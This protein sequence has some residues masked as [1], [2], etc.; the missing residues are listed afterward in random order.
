MIVV[1][2]VTITLIQWLFA[3]GGLRRKEHKLVLDVASPA[4]PAPVYADGITRAHDDARQ[5]GMADAIHD[6]FEDGAFVKFNVD[7]QRIVQLASHLFNIEVSKFN[8]GYGHGHHERFEE[9]SVDLEETYLSAYNMK[10]YLFDRI[11]HYSHYGIFTFI[12][13]YHAN[14]IN[15]KGGRDGATVQQAMLD[16]LFPMTSHEEIWEEYQTFKWEKLPEE[17]WQFC[18]ERYRWAKDQWPNLSD[19]ITTVWTLQDFG[20]IPEEVDVEMVIS[21]SSDNKLR[22][23]GIHTHA[24][25]TE[26]D[27]EELENKYQVIDDEDIE[28]SRDDEDDQN[29]EDE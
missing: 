14:W 20:L 27:P 6:M 19:R 5:R 26:I 15:P 29:N 23:I 21:V 3:N 22:R 28:S 4:P 18:R 8:L 1:S 7:S 10:D 11:E 25:E 13:K 2:G 16:I 12:E 17:I 9:P 24:A